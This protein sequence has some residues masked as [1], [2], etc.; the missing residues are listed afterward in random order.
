MVQQNLF[1]ELP[2]ED[3]TQHIANFEEICG[4]I[5]VQTISDEDLKRMFFAFSL[6]NKAKS[7][8][9]VGKHE[10]LAKDGERIPQQILSAI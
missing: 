6:A 8:T 9:K 2:H 3:V 7:W 10:Y 1:Y 4:T 5:K